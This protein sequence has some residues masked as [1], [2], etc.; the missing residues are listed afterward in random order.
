MKQ[1]ESKLQRQRKTTDKTMSC[2]LFQFFSDFVDF[3]HSVV[4]SKK[5]LNHKTPVMLLTP[6]CMQCIRSYFGY[7]FRITSVGK[8][9]M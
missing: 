4:V 5:T 7:I 2:L 9:S 6:S 1:F 8:N 3:L